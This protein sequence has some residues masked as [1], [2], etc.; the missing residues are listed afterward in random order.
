MLISG[1]LTSL[2]QVILNVCNNAAQAM[3]LP[4]TIE[5][6]T[7]VR[8]IE[9]ASAAAP[10]ELSPGQYVVISVTDPGR[11]M[12][13]TTLERVFEP[14]FTTRSEGNG[15]GLA[16]AR[17]TVYEHGGT[18]RIRSTP[19]TGTRVD[20]WLPCLSAAQTFPEHDGYS[21]LGRGGGE[22]VLVLEANRDRLLRHEEILAALGYE[23]VGFTQ[24]TDAE[25]AYLAE[26]TRF[27]VAL[28]CARQQE[29][30]S[31]LVLAAELREKAPHLPIL[32]ASSAP[33]DFAAPALA[34]AGVSEII[35]QPLNSAELAGTLARCLSVTAA[36]RTQ[37][38]SLQS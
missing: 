5:I 26:P 6:K 4:G 34:E 29:G 31:V 19:G 17:E 9:S 1:E 24:G 15:L 28:Y 33:G 36:L 23:P 21:A 38:V 18:V 27:D 37:E 32:L 22:T 12:D 8:Q 10:A 11:G 2:Q 30:A 3:D 13:E 25:A 16:M 7:D 35:R 14:F 20:I